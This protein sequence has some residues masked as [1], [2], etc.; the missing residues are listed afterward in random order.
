[1]TT[2]IEETAPEPRPP[3]G[4]RPSDD[5]AWD[6]VLARDTAWD[7][8][9]VYAVRTTGVYCRP[10][11]PSR[12]PHRENVSFF[13][14]ADEA[15][16]AG[17]RACQRCRPRSTRPSPATRAVERAR[18]Y[19]DERLDAGA[20]ERM[21][22]DRLAREVGMSPYHLQR[23]FKR[24]LGVTPAEYVRAGRSERLKRELRRGETVSRA[25]YGAGFGSS[26]RVYEIADAQ[27]GMTPAAYRTGG[28]GVEIRYTITDSPFGR[29][30]VAATE[31]GVCA[32][33]LGDH[34][35]MLTQD[36]ANEY[37]NA[38]IEHANG[39]RDHFATWVNAIVR[40][41]EGTSRRLD[42]PV[43]LRATAFQWRVWR[44]LQNIPYGETRSYSDVARSIGAP[45]AARAVA[46]ACANNHVALVIPCHRVVREGGALGGYRW[47]IDRKQRLLAR[48]RAVA[49]SQAASTTSANQG[50]RTNSS[51]STSRAK[52]ADASM[53]PRSPGGRR[54]SR[55][56]REPSALGRRR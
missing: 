7:G 27:L 13:A 55:V 15:E 26:S 39:D 21:T 2:K 12:R 34:D 10:T 52:S 3:G 4:D 43:D 53:K 11:C 28:R 25:T 35:R 5:T 9:F 44:A 30:L 22:L 19:L 45:R 46:S 48:E 18:Q 40:H 6:A 37:P 47:G 49:T 50:S 24:V 23:T 14:G 51:S 32:V 38:V 31:R 29:L 20:D 56:S 54:A 41:L 1:M 36:L 33:K 16:H 8:R 17:F 42:V